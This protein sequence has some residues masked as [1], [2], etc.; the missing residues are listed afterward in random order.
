M[1][2]SITIQRDHLDEIQTRITADIPNESCGLIAGRE[3]ETVKVFPI[4]NILQSPVRYEMDPKQQIKA[5]IEIEEEDLDLLAIYHSHPNGPPIPS[6][7]DIA[8][9]MYPD[10]VYLIFSPGPNDW[11]SRGFIINQKDVREVQINIR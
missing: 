10:S 2:E 4:D 11:I 1:I 9:A 8:E 7:T 3:N 6:Q 5:L